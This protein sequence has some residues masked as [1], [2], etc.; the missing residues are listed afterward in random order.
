[1]SIIGGSK[2]RVAFGVADGVGG[3]NDQ[4]V[5]P[6]HF[7]QGLCGLMAGTAYSWRTTGSTIEKALSPQG[8][9]QKA[10]DAV[11]AQ[12]DIVAGSSTACLGVVDDAGYLE[13]T[14]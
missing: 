2:H 11:L 4:G 13:T 5:D 9:L 3:W 1:M 8:L 6:S 7:S 14:K 12:P 10:Y